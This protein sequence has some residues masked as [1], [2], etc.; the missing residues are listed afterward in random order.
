MT[1][2][3]WSVRSKLTVRTSLVTPVRGFRHFPW[4][5]L[6]QLL[7]CSVYEYGPLQNYVISKLLR[8]H[9]LLFPKY[10][11]NWRYGIHD[12]LF[13]ACTF[14]FH[15]NDYSIMFNLWTIRTIPSLN[16]NRNTRYG[17]QDDFG[18]QGILQE[19]RNIVSG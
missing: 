4:I 19:N 17:N 1:I 12:T 14:Y 5:N 13:K 10:S 7:I 3:A 8:K 6:I 11:S 18:D 9:I 2:P 16:L 15:T